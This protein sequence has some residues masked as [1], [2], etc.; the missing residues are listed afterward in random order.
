[1]K[2]LMRNY[3]KTTFSLVLC[4]SLFATGLYPSLVLASSNELPNNLKEAQALESQN[5]QEVD[6]FTEITSSSSEALVA[7]DGQDIAEINN[8]QHYLEKTVEGYGDNMLNAITLLLVG[9]VAGTMLSCKKKTLSSNIF[10]IGGVAYLAGEA[11]TAFKFK[12]EMRRE[13]IIYNGNKKETKYLDEDQKRALIAMDESYGKKLKA[14]KTK[15]GFTTAGAV[16]FQIAAVMSFAEALK[17]EKAR[18][19]MDNAN[20]VCQAG[21]SA[22]LA[23]NPGSS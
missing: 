4:W 23:A 12:R 13:I 17:K 21:G 2:V 11:L 16:A 1:M 15:K 5:E 18:K 19:K 7:D 10:I 20:K 14:I 3:F 22:E 8:D 9:W 6:A